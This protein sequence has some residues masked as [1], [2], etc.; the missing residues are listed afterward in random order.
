L[1]ST[2]S[3][4]VE[5][6]IFKRKENFLSLE[7]TGTVDL[8]TMLNWYKLFEVDPWSCNIIYIP[9]YVWEPTSQEIESGQGKGW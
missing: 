2:Y 7:N 8:S 9:T 5:V 3:N 1:T 6:G 4:G